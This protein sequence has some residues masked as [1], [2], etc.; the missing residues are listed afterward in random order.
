MRVARMSPFSLVAV[1]SYMISSVITA[2][3]RY[4]N[5]YFPLLLTHSPLKLA[6]TLSDSFS[7]M[8]RAGLTRS[9]D[10]VFNVL[11]RCMVL[12]SSQTGLRVHI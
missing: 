8:S 3:L 11:L 1:V 5:L 4:R 2:F 12:W 6:D 10:P 9:N 7:S